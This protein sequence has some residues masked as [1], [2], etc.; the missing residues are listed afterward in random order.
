LQQ[1]HEEKE[2]EKSNERYRRDT[3]R[4]M[5]HLN[6]DRNRGSRGRSSSSTSAGG[7]V[8]ANAN[9]NDSIHGGAKNDSNNDDDDDNN[10]NKDNQQELDKDDLAPKEFQPPIHPHG[11]QLAIYYSNK[12]A[13]LMHLDDYS[14]A[15]KCCNIAIL[16]DSTYSKAYIRRMTCYEQRQEME[17]AL[18]D[19]KK[20]WN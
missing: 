8:N 9:T 3:E 12:A 16:V 7:N 18:A 4:K 11:K 15:L 13:S 20:H 5:S 17:L 14:E 6:I 2:R 10:N 1:R 19:A